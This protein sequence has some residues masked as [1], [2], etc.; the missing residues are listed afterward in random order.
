MKSAFL[1][2]HSDQEFTI[3]DITGTSNGGYEEGAHC[4]I[5]HSPALA[6]ARGVLGL[7][8][9]AEPAGWESEWSPGFLVQASYLM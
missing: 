5:V 8:A 7:F 2:I 4:K 6:V 9:S 1:G 3:R